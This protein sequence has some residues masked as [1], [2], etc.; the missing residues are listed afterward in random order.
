MVVPCAPDRAPGWHRQPDYT[1][2]MQAGPT[3][4]IPANEY[5]RLRW[6]NRAGWTREILAWPDPGAWLW[7]LSIAELEDAAPF[8]LFPG[9]GRELVLLRGDGLRLRFEDDPPVDLRPPHGRHRFD[10]AR[11]VTGEP[12]G[13]CEV[14]NLMWRRP[15]VAAELWHRPLAGAM[16]T[17]V[18]PGTS[19]IVHLLGGRARIA[20][21]ALLPELA[22]SD[23]AV[24]CAQE[25]R[26][27]Y[28]IEGSG[29]ALLV[30]I[31]AAPG[32]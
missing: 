30:R 21:D 1:G 8:S 23:T 24:L 32:G 7:R 11:P 2:A 5:R 13:R 28:R 19:W 25:S 20:G 15:G 14:F 31:A 6:A 27:R 9:R 22:A 18:E 3:R 26:A 4:V 16:L 10:G 17:F 29:E 12:E